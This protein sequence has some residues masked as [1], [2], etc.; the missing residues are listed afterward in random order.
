MKTFLHILKRILNAKYPSVGFDFYLWTRAKNVHMGLNCN[1]NWPN[2]LWYGRNLVERRQDMNFK[3]LV[4]RLIHATKW[5]F[6]HV[7][8]R[9]NTDFWKNVFKI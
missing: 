6:D 8:F 3:F 7:I 5:K 1:C 2:Y 4:S 9:K